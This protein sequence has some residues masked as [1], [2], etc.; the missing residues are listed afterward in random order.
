MDSN[1]VD[2]TN[3]NLK[4]IISITKLMKS[5]ELGITPQILSEGLSQ[6]QFIVLEALLHKGPLTVNEIIEKAFSSSGNIGLVI[7]NLEKLELV[8]KQVSE[9]DKRS[10]TIILTEKGRDVISNFFPKH[11]K[12]LNHLLSGINKEEKIELSG[13]MKKISLSIGEKL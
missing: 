8:K 4:L 10:R 2:E 1:K 6:T 3:V 5:V 12:T 11:V 7:K 9:I 13:L